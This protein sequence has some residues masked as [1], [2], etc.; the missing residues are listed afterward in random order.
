M[1]IF[2][3]FVVIVLGVMLFCG[4][5]WAIAK[6]VSADGKVVYQDSPCS[7]GS[8]ESTIGTAP[9]HKVVTLVPRAS[10]PQMTEDKLKSAVLSRLKDPDSANFKDLQVVEGGRALCGLVNSKNSYGG[11]AGFKRFVADSEG[12]YWQGDGSSEVDIGRVEAR[13]TFVPKAS[14]W[15]CLR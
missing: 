8:K 13:R 3:K 15:G 10:M 14:F 7:V 6:C 4:N 5:A 9:V 11:Y 2:S 1:K 12:V